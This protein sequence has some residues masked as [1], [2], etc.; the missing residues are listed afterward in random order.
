VGGGAKV[1]DGREAAKLVRELQPRVVIPVQYVSGTTPKDCDQGSVQPFLD[2]MA[3]TPVQRTG[4]RIN[5][6][7]SLSGGPVIK[8]MR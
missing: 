8:V 7:G 6:P 5:L 4:S 1:Y 3:G 2:A